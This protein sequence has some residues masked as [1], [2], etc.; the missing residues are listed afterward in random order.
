[1]QKQF[2]LLHELSM[3]LRKHDVVMISDQNQSL[4]IDTHE[5]GFAFE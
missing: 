3:M 5:R 4:T 2:G 1:M